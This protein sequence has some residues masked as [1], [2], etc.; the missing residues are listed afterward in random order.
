M[1]RGLPSL[2]ALALVVGATATAPPPSTPPP[3]TPP[4]AT[5]PPT[6]P[7]PSPPPF[8]PPKPPPVP[9]PPRAP[10]AVRSR[11]NFD[12]AMQVG[13]ALLVGLAVVLF[14]V[15]LPIIV[16]GLWGV[17]GGALWGD[18]CKSIPLHRHDALLKSWKAHAESHVRAHQVRLER[19]RDCEGP[20]G[21][22]I[23]APPAPVVWKSEGGRGRG[24]R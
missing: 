4:P 11:K 9:L 16:C 20:D 3:S 19:G 23:V 10:A 8:P 24:R 2:L 6:S 12:R 22:V 1:P 14:L 21:R 13:T 17:G 15:V 18:E 7:T 5:P